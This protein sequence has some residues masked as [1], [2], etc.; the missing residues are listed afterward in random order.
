MNR[1]FTALILA[2]T[3]ALTLAVPALAAETPVST[4]AGRPAEDVNTAGEEGSDMAEPVIPISGVVESLPHSVLYYGRVTGISR[5]ENGVPTRLMMESDHLGEYIFNLSENTLWVDSG[6]GK[7][8][9]PATLEEGESIY[10][11]HS[12]VST[13]SLPPQSAAFVV[14]RNIPQDAGCAMYH[15]VEE[16]AANEDGSLRYLTDNGGLYVTVNG[17]TPLS[18]YVAGERF[19]LADLKPGMR[20]MAWYDIVLESYPGQT[21]AS[22]LM[23]L[24]AQGEEQPQEA[25][26]PSVQE[27][28]D[29]LPLIL[30]KE[31]AQITMELDGRVPNMAGRYESGAAMVPVAAVAQA[32][33]FDVTYTPGQEGQPALVTVESESFQ[34]RLNVGENQIVGVTKIPGAVGMTAPQD[35]GKAPYIVEPGTAWAP[36]Q[37]FEMLGKTVTMEGNNLTIK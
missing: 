20:V 14:V 21:S 26:E 3:L 32:L 2:S 11:F 30:P 29:K 34:V 23:F 36:A 4:Q 35:Y 6:E 9:D 18:S 19:T 24:P 22:R 15:V 8:S 33:G 27:L 28:P 13:R 16:V 12:P 7:A 37:L 5:D 25:G 31:G 10:V 1:K 17:D